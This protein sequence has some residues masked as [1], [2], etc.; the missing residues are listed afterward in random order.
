MTADTHKNQLVLISFVDAVGTGAFSAAGVVLFSRLLYLSSASIASGL[1]IASLGAAAFL[2]PV[3]RLAEGRS[4]GQTMAR[5]NMGLAVLVVLLLLRGGVVAFAA[6]MGAIV[7]L[8]RAV[9]AVRGAVLGR[10]SSDRLAVRART[11]TV[12]NVGLVF[13]GAAAAVA[14]AVGSHAAL[15]LLVVIDAGS[16]LVCAVLSTTLGDDRQPRTGSAY[17]LTSVTD[18]RYVFACALNTCGSLHNSLLFVALPL[19][20]T[21]VLPHSAYLVPIVALINT[22]LVVL[23]Q[24]RLVRGATGLQASLR[25]Q[26]IAGV[27]ILAACAVMTASAT[28]SAGWRIGL[29]VA[30]TLLLTIAEMRQSAAGW[31]IAYGLAPPDRLTEYQALFGV[32]STIEQVLGPLLA[33]F[34]ILQLPHGL[35]WLIVGVGVC[36]VLTSGAVVLGRHN[37]D[38]TIVA[39]PARRATAAD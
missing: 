23:L 27:I 20:I 34:V 2:V 7:L 39:P 21:R 1:A 26:A 22:A 6:V 28:T 17:A 30:A 19:W 13:G 25:M 18:A 11:R 32:S 36:V 9:S 31:E 12:A 29:C 37:P 35:G 3:G 38:Q 14:L 8:E 16:F 33:G 24:Q 15:V 4:L 5:L 10:V